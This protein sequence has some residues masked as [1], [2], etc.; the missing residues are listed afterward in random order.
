[1]GQSNSAPKNSKET[2]NAMATARDMYVAKTA[3]NIT[4]FQ[5][6]F[7]G[8]TYSTDI[9]SGQTSDILTAT[10]VAKKQLARGGDSLTK[11]DLIHLVM[12]LNTIKT[13]TSYFTKMGDISSTM[14]R[15]N[16]V[17]IIRAT[18][19]EPSFVKSVIKTTTPISAPV[20]TPVSTPVLAPVSTHLSLVDRGY[21][22]TQIDPYK[23]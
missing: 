17:G 21:F 20:P 11:D 12:V 19:Y 13:G 23:Y 2:R 9:I 1:M 15:E 8:G 4:S 7:I 22:T 16:L 5:Q 18:I 3:S 6:E 10:N 14:T